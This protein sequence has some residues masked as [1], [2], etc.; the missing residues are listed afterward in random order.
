MQ[1]VRQLL[2]D[3]KSG[4]T[5]RW[6]IPSIELTEQTEL[7]F[8]IELPRVQIV[9]KLDLSATFAPNSNPSLLQNKLFHYYMT[10]EFEEVA[11]NAKGQRVYSKALEKFNLMPLLLPATVQNKE[12][13]KDEE[14]GFADQRNISINVNVT[15]CRLRLVLHCSPL[16]ST[17]TSS[18]SS[19]SS[20]QSA[21][22]G[23]SQQSTVLGHTLSV[24][25]FGSRSHARSSL[26]YRSRRRALFDA[27]EF[28]VNILKLLS[29]GK[30]STELKN[31][32]LE[33]LFTIWSS[34]ENIDYC[35]QRFDCKQFLKN[36]IVLANNSTA[37]L[38]LRL[39]NLASQLSAQ[40]KVSS[41]LK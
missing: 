38:S 4:T 30:P 40:F 34:R 29:E 31:A 21:S 6:E 10:L 13:E 8:Q 15:T 12:T 18:S 1:E 14:T 28:H 19:Q 17:S 35:I 5:A 25:L 16:P 32:C 7:E 20:T 27:L 33:L 9:D 23:Q 24:H 2:I 41:L 11:P 26:L 22:V 39:L 36:N 3:E 37:R